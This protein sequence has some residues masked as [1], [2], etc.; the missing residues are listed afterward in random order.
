MSY[1]FTEH[2]DIILV[3]I[4]KENFLNKNHFLFYRKI[5]IVFVFVDIKNIF[6]LRG[7]VLQQGILSPTSGS[8]SSGIFD[9]LN[10]SA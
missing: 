6:Y 1:E 4:N 9:S 8:V 7:F 3:D 10:F 5:G 2:L